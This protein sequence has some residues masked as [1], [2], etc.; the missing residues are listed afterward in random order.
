MVR[1]AQ[2]A[3][4]MQLITANSPSKN[5]FKIEYLEE[6]VGRIKTSSKKWVTWRFQVADHSPPTDPQGMPVTD[7]VVASPFT[8]AEAPNSNNMKQYCVS[9]S[10]SSVSGK[11]E[12]DVNGQNVWFG[13]RSGAAI[14]SH[15]WL[16]DGLQLE[17]IG[18]NRAPK[19]HVSPGF[20]S[21]DLMIN[22][23]LFE[24][25]PVWGEQEVIRSTLIAEADLPTCIAQVV[26]PESYT[27]HP[28]S[29]DSND[30]KATA[31]Q[32]DTYY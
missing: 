29:G 24:D 12:I 4:T 3:S 13:R 18:T 23:H 30:M 9:V 25:L 14:L 19:R 16:E 1:T 6:N 15:A 32:F 8:Q 26:Y 2:T 31:N 10:W 20:R 11:Q 27:W 17:V 21:F 7:L 28:S 5:I 22:G